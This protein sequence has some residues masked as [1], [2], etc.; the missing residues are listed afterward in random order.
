MTTIGQEISSFLTEL[1]TWRKV[2]VGEHNYYVAPYKLPHDVQVG[3][4]VW[5]CC[6][7]MEMVGK[8]VS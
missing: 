7:G 4:E 6:H 3:D 1:N 8:V 2:A 5:I